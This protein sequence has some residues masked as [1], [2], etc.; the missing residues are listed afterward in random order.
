MK[1]KDRH[2]NS[3]NSF[4]LLIFDQFSIYFYYFLF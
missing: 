1:L 2:F 3:Y 4:Y